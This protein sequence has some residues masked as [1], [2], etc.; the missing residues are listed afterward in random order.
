VLLPPMYVNLMYCAI[1]LCLSSA[2]FV[3]Q[4]Q[5]RLLG[6]VQTMVLNRGLG[7]TLLAWI[8]SHPNVRACD[9]PYVQEMLK[10]EVN[11]YRAWGC[12]QDGVRCVCC[13]RKSRWAGVA[14]GEGSRWKGPAERVRDGAAFGV[15]HAAS[16]CRSLATPSAV[17]SALRPLP[18][19]DDT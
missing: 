14:E 16:L 8:A 10:A 12:D 11:K 13:N 2:A 15:R 7:I 4:K 9:V 1:P 17:E 18:S 3:A 19:S 6:R 5:S